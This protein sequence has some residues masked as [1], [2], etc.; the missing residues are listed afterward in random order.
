[1]Y[2]GVDVQSARGSPFAILDDS[3]RLI[4]NG[5]LRDATQLRDL[6]HSL[7]GTRS[8][9]VGIDAPRMPMPGPRRWASERGRW[10]RRSVD[11]GRHCEIAVRG[12]G[13][14]NPQWTPPALNAEPWMKLGF[15]MFRQLGELG[16]VVVHEVFPSASYAMLKTAVAPEITLSLGGFEPGAKDMLDAVVAA[17]TIMEFEAGRGCEVGGGDGLGTIVLPRPLGVAEAQH[18][19]VRWPEP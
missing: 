17:L 8:V 19:S 5:W 6:V 13:L 2:V 18:F 14:A 10:V 16:G 9:A 15:E 11:R 1:M 12:L 3:A 7:A 4:R